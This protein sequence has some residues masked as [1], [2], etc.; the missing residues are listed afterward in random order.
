MEDLRRE[1]GQGGKGR[2]K[3]V[4]RRVKGGGRREKREGWR[5]KGRRKKRE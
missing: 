1:K 2:E 4:K 3:E 5:G